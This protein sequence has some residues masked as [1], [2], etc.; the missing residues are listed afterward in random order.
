MIMVHDVHREARKAFR[1]R[2]DGRLAKL[3][4]M[5]QG[6]G[7]VTA[8][9]LAARMGLNDRTIYRYVEQLRARGH[10]IQGERGLGYMLRSN[11]K[12]FA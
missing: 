5:M 1:R 3:L 12:R 4:S 9:Q 2:T 10:N 6:G 11:V 8:Q 7:L